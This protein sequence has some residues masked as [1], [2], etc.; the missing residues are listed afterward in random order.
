M[1]EKSSLS[2]AYHEYTF[3]RRR[4]QEIA[5][6]VHPRTEA[7]KLTARRYWLQYKSD[8][9]ALRPELTQY[10]L[11]HFSQVNATLADLPRLVQETDCEYL[12]LKALALVLAARIKTSEHQPP[13]LAVI[14][15][16]DQVESFFQTL[17]KAL[18]DK[19]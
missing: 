15:E 13:A 4:L 9:Y 5:P 17:K 3:S 8:I 11:A 12:D 14:N 7:E 10:C 18:A 16:D 19:S 2:P 1:K 6:R